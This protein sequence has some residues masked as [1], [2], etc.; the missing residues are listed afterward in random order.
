[1]NQNPENHQ[2][3]KDQISNLIESYDPS[4]SALLEIAVDV[5]DRYSAL[6]QVSELL[7]ASHSQMRVLEHRHA[8]LE[9]HGIPIQ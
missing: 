2:A 6:A 5:A 4:G 1:M 8:L 3:L 7:A 9:K